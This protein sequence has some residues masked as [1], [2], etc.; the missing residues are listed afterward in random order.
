MRR[1]DL[2][3]QSDTISRQCGTAFGAPRSLEVPSGAA[4]FGARVGTLAMRVFAAFARR[5]IPG[6]PHFC[7]FSCTTGRQGVGLPT[8]HNARARDQNAV[9]YCVQPADIPLG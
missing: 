3:V 8:I 1:A 2:T 9:R 5:A 6:R 7:C 4:S